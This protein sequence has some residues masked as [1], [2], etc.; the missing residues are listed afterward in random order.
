MF[1][2]LEARMREAAER[3]ARERAERLAGEMEA[4]LP[5]GIRAEAG[6]GGIVLSGRGLLRRWALDARLRRLSGNLR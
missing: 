5:A 2:R 1:E 6:E 3:R 4:V